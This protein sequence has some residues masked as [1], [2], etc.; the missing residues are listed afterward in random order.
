MAASTAITRLGW[1]APRARDRRSATRQPLRGLRSRSTAWP[2]NSTRRHAASRRRRHDPGGHV[3]H[4]DRRSISTP[5]DRCSVTAT[6]HPGS[7]RSTRGSRGRIRVVRCVTSR[8]WRAWLAAPCSG[9][10]RAQRQQVKNF[11]L[12]GDFSRITHH[13]NLRRPCA[14]FITTIQTRTSVLASMRALPALQSRKIFIY[15]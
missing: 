3:R 10:F 12:V 15:C 9:Y 5:S 11:V 7:R 8:C 4:T 2:D 1:A 14:A 6:L 13:P